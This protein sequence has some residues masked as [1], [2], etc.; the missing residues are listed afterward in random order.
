MLRLNRRPAQAADL[1]I[2]AL[3]TAASPRLGSVS[4]CAV[5]QLLD[6]FVSGECSHR[7]DVEIDQN[8]R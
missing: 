3:A 8:S 7:G 1:H 2:P 6:I 4:E 5:A